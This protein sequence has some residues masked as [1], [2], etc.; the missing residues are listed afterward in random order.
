M[1]YPD[2][3]SPEAIRFAGRVMRAMGPGV[4]AVGIPAARFEE[5]ALLREAEIA[6]EMG[7]NDVAEE[8]RASA[9]VESALRREIFGNL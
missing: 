7:L 1:D 5:M 8:I 6:A 4:A 9:R 2:V 3:N